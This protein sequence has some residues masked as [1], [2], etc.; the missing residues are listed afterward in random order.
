[1][2]KHLFNRFVTLYAHKGEHAIPNLGFCLGTLFHK[3]L[4][5]ELSY[6]KDFYQYF[7]VAAAWTTRTDHC[8]PSIT[9]SVLG[10]EIQLQIYDSRHWYYKEKRFYEPGEEMR[11]YEERKMKGQLAADIQEGTVDLLDEDY[12]QD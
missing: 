3:A 12:G 2:T 11:L 8:G 9:L 1:M 5:F 4:E 6:T 10:L 7:Y